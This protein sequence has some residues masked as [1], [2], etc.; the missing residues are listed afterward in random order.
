MVTTEIPR[1]QLSRALE[2][3]SARHNGWLV[4]VDVL[5]ST[6]G[7]QPAIAEVPLSGLTW[8]PRAESL[9][10]SVGRGT[11]HTTH[12]IDR[13]AHLWLE[14]TGNGS[15]AALEVESAD[16]T[17]TIVRLKNAVP[18]QTVDGVPRKRPKR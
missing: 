10:I 11:A 9:S 15:D 7:A 17:K 13:A 8:E 2:E 16:G 4:S 6:L 3:F 1:E 12:T 5:S 18:P 14:R